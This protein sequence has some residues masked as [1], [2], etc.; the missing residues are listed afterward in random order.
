MC[1]C[2]WTMSEP[3]LGVGARR[4]ATA[5]IVED[6]HLELIAV[7]RYQLFY[8]LAHQ[9]L[10]ER[11]SGLWDQASSHW[12]VHSGGVR[13]ASRPCMTWQNLRGR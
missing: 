1:V 6:A 10:G 3:E 4:A 2:V 12:A 8:L 7:L 9:R 5:S 13:W 11:R